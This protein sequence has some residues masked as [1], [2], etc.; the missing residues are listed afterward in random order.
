MNFLRG[1]SLRQLIANFRNEYVAG[2]IQDESLC[3]HPIDQFEVWLQEAVRN[4]LPEPNAFHLATVAAGGQPSGRVMLL[5]GFDE[6]GFVF[7][8]HYQSRKGEE[9]AANPKAAMTFLWIE[10]FRQVRVEGRVERVSEAE[11]DAYFATR[12]RG[13]QLGAWASQQSKRLPGSEW[14]TQAFEKAEE[15]Y[16]GV[17]PPRPATWGGYRLTPDRVEFWQG[18]ASR[19]H[20]RVCYLRHESGWNRERLYP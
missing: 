14:L 20:D 2:G 13:S 18:R 16:R 7:F 8:T 12:P 5:K 4:R 3:A 11:S 6:Q 19:L 10:L 9:L 15:Q 17:T 1:K